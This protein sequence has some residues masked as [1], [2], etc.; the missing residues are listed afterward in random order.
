MSDHQSPKGFIPGGRGKNAL[1]AL[2]L[3]AL[4]VPWSA[5]LPRRYG[6]LDIDGCP[7]ASDVVLLVNHL[8][9]TP[10]LAP[11]MVPYA[12]A[13]RDSDVDSD[14]VDWIVN[15]ALGVV[16]LWGTEQKARFTEPTC[17]LIEGTQDAE[18]VIEL[19]DYAPGTS[20]LLEV[21]AEG[22]SATE[23]VDFT[24]I[25]A[26]VEVDVDHAVI[27]ISIPDDSE[28]E[29]FETV[30]IRITGV[31]GFDVILPTRHVVVIE[32]NDRLWSGMLS[33]GEGVY[34]D[35][36]SLD[37]VTLIN[38]GSIDGL[39]LG[40]T[41]PS[42]PAGQWPM[43]ISLSGGGFNALAQGIPVP[44][45]AFFR[46]P[47]ERELV[48]TAPF[49]SISDQSFTGEFEETFTS[50]AAPHL[51]HTITGRFHLACAIDPPPDI[52][53]E[54]E[55]V[56][57]GAVARGHPV[58]VASVV[59][60]SSVRSLRSQI[61]PPRTRVP[62]AEQDSTQVVHADY[63]NELRP[64]GMSDPAEGVQLAGGGVVETSESAPASPSHRLLQANF[65]QPFAR[66]L[67]DPDLID[68][69]LQDASHHLY[70]DP[71][72][73]YAPD[74][75]DGIPAFRY[76]ALLYGVDVPASGEA[77]LRA[78]FENM[79]DH[80]GPAERAVAL[81]AERRLRQA[82]IYQP[83]NRALRHVYLDLIN[84]RA[85]AELILARNARTEVLRQ[86]LEPPPPACFVIDNEI[87]AFETLVSPP[88]DNP[89][90][91]ALAPYGE[92]L[93]D[94]MGIQVSEIDPSRAEEDPPFGV[95][96]FQREEPS[97]FQY[98]AQYLRGGELT[99]V[100][101]EGEALFVGY[102]D[103]VVLFEILA[104]RAQIAVE[105]ARLHAM[106]ATGNDLDDADALI[107]ETLQENRSIGIVL[108]GLFPGYEPLPND[109]SGLYG[110][111][112]SWRAALTELQGTHEFL[113]GE[114]N[115]LGFT[116]DFL[117]L[118][119]NYDDSTL[120]TF[121]SLSSYIEAGSTAPL[122]RAVSLHEVALD[123]HDDYRGYQDQLADQFEQTF[124]SL[125][126]CLWEI[127]GAEYPE[128]LTTNPASN[129]GCEIHLQHLVI[130]QAQNRIQHNRQE[131]DNLNCRIENIVGLWASREAID[132]DLHDL[133]I[134]Y[135]DARSSVQMKIAAIEATQV[136]IEEW[137]AA[138]DGV[139]IGMDLGFDLGSYFHMAASFLQAG[140]EIG[141]GAAE[142][143]LEELAA[144]EQAGVVDLE[145]RLASAELQREINDILLDMQLAAIDSQEASL[146]LAQEAARLVALHDEANRIISEI[147]HQQQSLASRYFA[148]PIHQIRYQAAVLEA[149]GAFQNAQQWTFFMSRALQFK[150][151]YATPWSHVFEGR[152]FDAG[153][154]L[155]VRNAHELEHLVAA[156]R[157]HDALTSFT[158][159]RVTH[160]SRFS[161]RDDV[162]GLWSVG[163][164][165]AQF[166]NA[167][168]GLEVEIDTSDREITIPFATVRRPPGYNVFHPD[169]FADKIIQVLVRLPGSHTV[170]R[171]TLA[172]HL[173]YGG[174]ALMRPVEP[175]LTAPS[176][177]ITGW[178]LFRS[179]RW[180]HRDTMRVT[181]DM[182]L[183]PSSEAGVEPS[184]E[185]FNITQFGER[186]VAATDWILTIPTLDQGIPVIHI[187]EIDDIEI[188]LRHTAFIR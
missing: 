59:N 79:D 81:E 123:R 98:A 184:P 9:G 100:I 173:S 50:T 53:P 58:Q 25:P 30:E 131:M 111:I 80:W 169:N 88:D 63:I 148:D 165:I 46:A 7:T 29:G 73:S 185:D 127:C 21:V 52:P 97:R 94:R 22:T 47:L 139:S 120:D 84:D 17:T 13:D 1:T 35:V 164:P 55:D 149:A 23:G 78:R 18:I 2:I 67:V 10:A 145:G 99:P 158:N 180:Q 82:L 66:D 24:P 153:S 74:F 39:L 152:P 76:L 60:S 119:Q 102:K 85:R 138:A 15:S 187:D 11:E 6:D 142:G 160:I 146:L 101:G 183:V 8:H 174:T 62:Q 182:R 5:S 112:A 108:L 91:R 156:M 159:P 26:S 4:A 33:R 43:S 75:S 44:G 106:R 16:G 12:D 68:D 72:V 110:A 181:V 19:S 103:L 34:T 122:T 51:S 124:G 188:W 137:C 104:D 136:F 107:R 141:K 114:A 177:W 118:V 37:M 48:L 168:H 57:T 132:A 83:M 161:L 61:P 154:A 151:P 86:R 105:L 49:A 90:S 134:R 176:D 129:E 41:A 77:T 115:M 38:G 96:I 170:S 56:V 27:P 162:L 126:D 179:G 65:G 157:D 135:G 3:A 186:S 93:R 70:Y 42:F 89:H 140:A 117:M 95:H 54:T 116:E 71:S 128:A 32:D 121:D 167:L 20:V 150:Y 28:R 163:D 36:V 40:D 178:W 109:A 31:A 171:D 14:D 155:R 147:E 92:L 166:R 64:A 45:D 113:H 133:H 87:S 175:S 172:G 130:R 144:R 69:T 125:N 143:D